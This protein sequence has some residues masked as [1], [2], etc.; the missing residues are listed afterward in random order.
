[1]H[2]YFETS[3]ELDLNIEIMG[4]GK[5]ISAYVMIRDQKDKN[6]N[7]QALKFPTDEDYTL[8]VREQDQEFSGHQRILAP[9]KFEN[10]NQVNTKIVSL[11]VYFRTDPSF[12]DRGGHKWSGFSNF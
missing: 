3:T 10:R 1:M 5:L 9:I 7:L 8:H 4:F 12:K 2:F 6:G 11:S